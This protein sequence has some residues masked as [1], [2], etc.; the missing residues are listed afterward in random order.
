MY[1]CCLRRRC[2]VIVLL[3]AFF[4]PFLF[5]LY[6][7]A[8]DF[9][10]TD[11]TAVPGPVSSSAG[12]SGENR[13]DGPAV[14]TG[15]AGYLRGYEFGGEQ[16]F[17]SRSGSRPEDVQ[18]SPASARFSGFINASPDGHIEKKFDRQYR[19][20]R[21]TVWDAS[22]GGPVSVTRY[23]YSGDRATPL[24]SETR[25]DTASVSVVYTLSGQK[26]SVSVFSADESST[27]VSRDEYTYDAEDRLVRHTRT[28]YSGAADIM[29]VETWEYEYTDRSV[30]PDELYSENGVP[31]RQ[32]KYLDADV[33]EETV[34]LDGGWTVRA[35]YTGNRKTD[36]EYLVDGKTV[37]RETY[38][39]SSSR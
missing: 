4:S 39:P 30:F 37:K 11:G 38:K 33:R 34:F 12:S 35:R 8:N 9:S 36:E 7:T 20:V 25:T 31:V 15:H 29:P 22:G 27:P 17:I 5:P 23:E 10:E 21:E 16:T 13:E 24:S 6:G 19:L 14:Y 26:Q 28:T 3:L 1:T 32:T 2:P 18:V